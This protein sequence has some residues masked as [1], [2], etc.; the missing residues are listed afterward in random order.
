MT[1][2]GRAGR[3]RVRRGRLKDERQ[4]PTYTVRPLLKSQLLGE[5]FSLC[6]PLY[7][8]IFIYLLGGGCHSEPYCTIGSHGTPCWNR[9]SSSTILGMGNELKSS[10]LAANATKL[11]HWPPL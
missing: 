6:I 9:F 8:Y 4:T 3:V 11:S 10:G 5:L 7:F 2:Q 1:G